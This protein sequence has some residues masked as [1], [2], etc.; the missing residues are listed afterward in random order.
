MVVGPAPVAQITNLQLDLLCSLRSALVHVLLE[1]LLFPECVELMSKVVL[2]LVVGLHLPL[3]VSL[4]NK[5]PARRRR[6]FCLIGL[7]QPVLE[8]LLGSLNHPGQTERPWHFGLYQLI[9]LLLDK[10]SFGLLC[11]LIIA[12]VHLLWIWLGCRSC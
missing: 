11:R 3:K 4:F 5:L 9:D 2:C 10:L 7:D 1:Q 12:V 6:R 8:I